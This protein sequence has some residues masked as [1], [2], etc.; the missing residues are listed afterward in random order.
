V[1]TARASAHI[2]LEYLLRS[3]VVSWMEVLL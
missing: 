2:R 1:F 3:E